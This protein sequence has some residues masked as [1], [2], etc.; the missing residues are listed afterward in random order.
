MLT[1]AE[2]LDFVKSNESRHLTEP[3]LAREAG[4]VRQTKTGREQVLTKRFYNALLSAKGVEVAIGRAPGKT[5][6][7]VT[8]VHRSGVILLGRTYSERFG[9]N[10]GDELDIVLE[11]DAIRLVPRPVEAAEVDELEA[12]KAAKS[13]KALVA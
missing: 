10:A 3:E 4:Y 13:D 2:L 9:L 5:A 7:Y 11:D 6:Q 8:T 12:K 1:G